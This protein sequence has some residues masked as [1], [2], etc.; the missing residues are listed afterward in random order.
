G[1]GDAATVKLNSQTPPVCCCCIGTVWGEAFGFGVG[2]GVGFFNWKNKITAVASK[3]N[4][5]PIN[6]HI[7]HFP[8]FLGVGV[9]G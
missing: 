6:P 5:N 3:I 2:A 9:M 4:V 1:D 7:S 8:S